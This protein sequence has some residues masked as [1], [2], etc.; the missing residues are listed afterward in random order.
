[1]RREIGTCTRDLDDSL[2]QSFWSECTRDWGKM[3]AVSTTYKYLCSLW[4]WVESGAGGRR[5]FP[6]PHAKY[7]K[8]V[9]EKW[10]W[11]TDQKQVGSRVSA[12]SLWD[13]HTHIFSEQC[14]SKSFLMITGTKWIF[15]L[16]Y[17]EKNALFVVKKIF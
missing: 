1:M 12:L 6:H 10:P 2:L 17:K 7:R 16:P 4:K 11:G 9:I 13:T 8:T 15:I 14:R 3:N 5:V